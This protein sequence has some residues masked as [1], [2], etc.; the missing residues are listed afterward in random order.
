MLLKIRQ[1]VVVNKTKSAYVIYEWPQS[2]S[3]NAVW[4]CSPIAHRSRLKNA[5]QKLKPGNF[6]YLNVFFNNF[7]VHAF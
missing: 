1:I 5:L 7:K 6:F 2:M 3:H 4:K